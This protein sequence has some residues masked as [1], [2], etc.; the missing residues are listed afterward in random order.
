MTQKNT[1]TPPNTEAR[2]RSGTA[3]VTEKSSVLTYTPGNNNLAQHV[4]KIVAEFTDE[5]RAEHERRL[6]E[7]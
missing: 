1:K 6:V 5:E 3:K 2:W 7:L 4:S